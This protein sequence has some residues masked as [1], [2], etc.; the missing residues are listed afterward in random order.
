MGNE[1]KI[2]ADRCLATTKAGS[3]CKITAQEGSNYCHMHQH[4]AATAPE[5]PEEVQV[6]EPTPLDPE[7]RRRVEEM[8]AVLA[9]LN[10]LVEEMRQRVPDFTPPTFSPQVMLDWLRANVERF[11]PSLVK[12]IGQELKE[13]SA[14]DFRDPDM[15]KGIWFLITYSIQQESEELFERISREAAANPAVK[16]GKEYLE[17]LPTIRETRERI[18]QVP[19]VKETRDFIEGLPGVKEGKKFLASLP[20]ASIVTG[21]AETIDD[22]APKD[23]LDKDTWSGIWFVVNH[24]LK[25]EWEELRKRVRDEEDGEDEIIEVKSS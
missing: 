1:P 12:E 22:A 8:Q 13:A 10:A 21:L 25:T 14:E 2:K 3:R 24:S 17:G 16:R 19:G 18:E 20:G 4:L 7:T 9:E 5:V 6:E 11:T 15:W 23:F